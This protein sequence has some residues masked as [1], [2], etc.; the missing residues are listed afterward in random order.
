MGFFSGIQR[1]FGSRPRAQGTPGPHDDF[2]YS[3]LP[4]GGA[5]ASGQFVSPDTA[6]QSTAVYA[7]VKVLA[8]TLAAL[9]IH[10]Y[11]RLP[12]GGKDTARVHPVYDLLHEKPNS[13]QTAFEFKEMLMTQV[14][15]RGNAY[16]ELLPGRRGFVDQLIPV[17]PDA[18]TVRQNSHY[19][20]IYTVRG[21]NGAARELHQDGMLHFRGLSLDGIHGVSPITYHRET[22]GLSLATKEYGARFF[23]NDARPGGVLEHPGKLTPESA[24]RL[25]ES[26][27]EKYAGR[28]RGKTAVLEEGMKF[29]PIA[30]TNEDAQYIETQEFTMGDIARLFRVP[31][32]LIGLNDKTATYA[33]AEQFFLSFAVHSVMPWCVRMEQ[34]LERDLITAPQTYFIK[35][36]LAGLLRGDLKSRYDAYAVGRNGGWLTPNE[37]RA[38][39][40]MNPRTDSGG[41]A[42]LDALNMARSDQP[43]PSAQPKPSALL[44]SKGKPFLTPHEWAQL[45]DHLDPVPVDLNQYGKGLYT[46]GHAR[47]GEGQHS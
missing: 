24:K 35:Y 33:S 12:N 37:I 13:W 31:G 40:E 34:A 21:A 16:A 27:N 19:Q 2:W 3:S 44:D 39:E 11:K 43:A 6:L 28:G 29:T 38:L 30:V 41:D 47:R 23:G 4:G 14:L 7:C 10:I 45:Q 17:Q 5:T 46:N 8:E 32:V 42:F 1:L 25:G 15:L 9:P 20:L 18:V 26:W 36:N 22:I